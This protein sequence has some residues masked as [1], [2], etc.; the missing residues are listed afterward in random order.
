[1]LDIRRF[2][3]ANTVVTFMSFSPSPMYLL[4]TLEAVILKNT[5]P[6][7]VATAFANNVL[8]V[9]ANQNRFISI[10]TVYKHAI[11]PNLEVQTARHLA[12]GTAGQ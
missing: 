7:S 3:D 4:V 9:P 1:M 6:D 8:P 10:W 2:Y 11:N 5:N 12:A